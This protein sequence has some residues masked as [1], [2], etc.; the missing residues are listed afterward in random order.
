[1]Q[2]AT[3]QNDIVLLVLMLVRWRTDVGGV[4]AT[5]RAGVGTRAGVGVG[6]GLDAESGLYG[7]NVSDG[8]CCAVVAALHCDIP[9]D[10]ALDHIVSLI[11]VQQARLV[12]ED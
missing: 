10:F 3:A 12:G 11:H 5:G 8:S 2:Q 1:M 7:F 6:A 4:L 9:R